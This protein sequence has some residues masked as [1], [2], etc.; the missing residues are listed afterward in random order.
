MD[1]WCSLW[2]WPIDMEAAPPPPNRDEFLNEV[3]L[4]LIGDIRLPEAGIYETA[5]LFGDEYAEHASEM[6]ARITSETGMLELERL[7]DLFPRLKFIDD[8]ATDRGF[9]HWDLLVSDIFYGKRQDG[10][11]RSG[12]DLMVG[13]LPWVKVEWDEGGV[14]SDFDPTVGLRKMTAPNVQ[15]IR[16]EIIQ[17]IPELSSTYIDEIG[18]AKSMQG[19]LNSIQNFPSLG[20]VQ[21][22]LYKC[23]I[24]LSWR[25][26]S[27]TGVAG[28]LHPEGVYKDPSGGKLRKEIYARLR[29]HFQFQNSLFLFHDI[30]HRELF[31]VNIYGSLSP[32]PNFKHIAN[33]LATSTVDA[34]FEHSGQG[35]VPGIKN[36]E[37][38]WE[39]VGHNHRVV[40]IGPR[41]L[42]TF[43]QALDAEDTAPLMARLPAVHSIELMEVLRKFAEQPRRLRDLDNEYMLSSGYHE[44]D[45][46][47]DGLIRRETRFPSSAK[48]L[49][50]S[51]PHFFVGAPL[52]KTPR[53]IC[54]EKAHYDCI[55]QVAIP[56]DY[57]PRTNYVPSEETD[58][59]KLPNSD[60]SWPKYHRKYKQINR[61]MVGPASERTLISSI[62]PS[63]VGHVNTCVST[64]FEDHSTLL[65]CH[66]MMVSLPL[67]GFLKLTGFTHVHRNL[68]ENFP[69]PKIRPS[70]RTA[71]HARLVGLTCLTT[72]YGTLWE[73]TYD[74]H[75]RFESWTRSDDRLPWKYFESLK[76][77]WCRDT[78]LRADYSRRQ[79]LVEIDVL[80]AMALGLTLE[81][82]LTLYRVQFPVMREY[83]ADTWYDTEGRIVFTPS[84]G[85]PGVGLP[86][87]AQKHDTDYGLITPERTE[88][89]IALGWEDVKY[90]KEGIVTRRILDDTLPGGPFE[91]VIEYH[92]PF[93]RCDREEDYR[94]AW[95]EFSSRFGIKP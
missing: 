89:G 25:A 12:F 24:P 37:G 4:V 81:E 15:E 23:F 43:A 62:E 72:H 47:R 73:T 16:S 31:S 36:D 49:I 29:A 60:I 11:V 46:Q 14:I 21:A 51:G 8:F 52:S 9:L 30:A 32:D 88:S 57:L 34:C 63:D 33:I 38:T 5:L 55:D 95:D 41:A 76:K 20:G 87:K 48:E 69:I 22:D 93:D 84:K 67:D 74:E 13:N 44:T 26:I 90:L 64:V 39:I 17:R 42:S 56:D 35:L 65:D 61:E 40:K 28:F 68:I 7:F 54:T 78:P 82:L 83:E 50:L 94:A 18:Q 71:I 6:A 86:R 3:S 70:E 19:Y 80:A 77:E 59:K 27:S 10:G 92:A 75:F 91:R 45:A 53:R 1:Y 2:F 66:A 85:L 79:A 58:D